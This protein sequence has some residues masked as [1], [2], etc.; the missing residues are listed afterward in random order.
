MSTSRVTTRIGALIGLAATA[1]LALGA[2]SQGTSA[3]STPD[4]KSSG[5][6]STAAGFPVTVE[7]GYGEI[8]IAE[9]PERIVVLGGNYSDMLAA[10][11]VVP[12]ATSIAS[13]ATDAA[14][15][16]GVYPWLDGADLGEVDAAMIG[17]DYKAQLEA[18]A[19]HQ[20]DLIL[21]NTWQV[22][23]DLYKQISE[24]APTFTG[25]HIGNNDWDETTE[26]LGKLTGEE[27]AASAAI[28][29]VEAAYAAAREKLP[30][31]EGLT[32]MSTRFDPNGFGFGNGSWLD[33]FGLVP[34][35][36]QDNTQSGTETVSLENIERMDA[37]VLII[38]FYETDPATLENDPRYAELPSVKNGLAFDVDFTTANAT[39]S[40]GPLSL[41]WAIERMVPEF[42]KSNLH[43]Q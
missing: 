3:D 42:E 8:T 39:N 41:T 35:E 37:D 4:E 30:E 32:Y 17:A 36:L 21:A 7:T 40:A 2:C 18:I 11:D 16:V 38:W 22:D 9:K 25:T 19:A 29:E 26:V 43:Q 14:S 6:A 23:E 34:A 5:E 31:L 27:E 15:I 24:I 33:G 13:T 20:P 12:V 28:A 10:M 1:T